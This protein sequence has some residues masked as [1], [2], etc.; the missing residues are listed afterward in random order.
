MHE[1]NFSR[2]VVMICIGFPVVHTYVPSFFDVD[3]RLLF[4]LIHKVDL[5]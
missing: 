2:E 1:I 5:Y 4:S 3:R